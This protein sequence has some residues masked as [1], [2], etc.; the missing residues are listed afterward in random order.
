MQQTSVVFT[1]DDY[2]TLPADGK[3]YE[4]IEGELY[5]TP[6]PFTDHQRILGRL[7]RLLDEFV[8]KNNLGEVFL[9]PT[10]V[11]LSMT[12]VVQPD[13]L[14]VSKERSNII[15]KKNIIAAPDLVIEILSEATE[16]T[17]RTAKKAMYEQF[18]VREYWIVDPEQKLVEVYTLVGNKFSESGVYRGNDKLKS[19]LLRELSLEVN[20]IFGG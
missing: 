17:D 15:T 19:A 13:I 6:A 7:F 14:F 20:K 3:R 4:I 12:S 11:V 18:G 9:A 1:Y 16:K 10:D 8:R 5:M 2:L